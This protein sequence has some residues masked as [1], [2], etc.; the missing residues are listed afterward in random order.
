M[1]NARTLIDRVTN[2]P[3]EGIRFELLRRRQRKRCAMSTSQP[4]VSISLFMDTSVAGKYA[5]QPVIASFKY[6]E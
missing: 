2:Y 5:F 3:P 4:G 6:S 1:V